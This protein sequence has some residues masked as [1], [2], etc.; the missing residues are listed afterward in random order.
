MKLYSYQ[1]NAIQA[2]LS[3]PSHTQLISM[4][5]GTGKTITFLSVAKRM[6]K[7]SLILVHRKELLQQTYEKAKLLGYQEED[8]SIVT[9]EDKQK[10]KKLSIAMVPTL[11]RNLDM[12]DAD[13]VEMV[14]IDEAHHSTA[15]SF[16]KIISY[17]QIFEKKKTLLGFTAT[18]LRGDGKAL[19]NL[20]ASHSFKMTLSEATKN[21]YICPVYGVRVDIKKSLSEIETK[22][23]D[24]DIHE[25]DKIMNC[26][27]VN[28]VIAERCHHFKNVPCIIFCTSVDHAKKIA[29]LLRQKKRK[30]I[31]VSYKNSDQASKKIIDL[32][33]EGKIEFLTNAIKLS[34]G[35]DHPSIKSV[36]IA[37][38]T[39]SPVLYKQM[40]GRGLR[41]HPSKSE[42]YVIEFGGNDEKMIVWE[43]IDENC[44]FQCSTQT[45]Q[46]NQKEALNFYKSKFFAS[47]IKIL[48]VR[49]SAF[50]FYE[51]LMRRVIKYKKIFTYIPDSDGFH[52]LETRM[53][54]YRDHKKCAVMEK[55]SLF[56]YICLWKETYKSFFVWN[57]GPLW[58]SGGTRDIINNQIAY[59]ASKQANGSLGKWYPSEEEPMTHRQSSFL[60]FPQKMNARKAEF[61]IEDAA[62][63]SAISK[64]ME[65]AII[66]KDLGSEHESLSYN[67]NKNTKIY[68][69]DG[70]Y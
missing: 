5:T 15:Q 34:E 36:V 47:N 28:E 56:G 7:K 21:G 46:K 48:N 54:V 68:E 32:F 52:L 13:S 63:K 67:Y 55:F 57:C 64:Y 22:Q 53:E 45:E 66:I 27:A 62:I 6:G 42:C 26:A 18:P 17:F 31:S 14:I 10:L 25:L 16:M 51:C 43:D 38:P 30:A 69:L 65:P 41:K 49:I 12:Y 58:E 33:K 9:S 59:Y 24:Y 2:I 44:T 23:G 20:Y 4:P 19:G 29:I 35:F 39:R 60:K 70:V 8:I 50:N 3:D 40:I 37:R 11:V 1:E 61:F